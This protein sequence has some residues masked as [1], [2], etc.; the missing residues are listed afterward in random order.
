MIVWINGAFGSGKTTVSKKLQNSLENS[1]IFD[2]ELVGGAISHLMPQNLK[3]N[4][5][6]DYPEWREWTKNLLI[7]IY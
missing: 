7:K 6:Q 4:D 3:L 2:P 5:F 1:T